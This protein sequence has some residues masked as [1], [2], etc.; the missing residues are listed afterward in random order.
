[1]AKDFKVGDLLKQ[2]EFEGRSRKSIPPRS[3]QDYT[4]HASKKQPQ[5]LIL[6]KTDHLAMD[7]GSA[8]T[9]VVRN[10]T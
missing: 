2:A 5:Y 3:R 4:V 9:L 1:M 8:L 6:D 7:K 10:N